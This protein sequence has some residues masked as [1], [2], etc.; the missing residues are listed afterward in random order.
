[1]KAGVNVLDTN[2]LEKDRT[3]LHYAALWNAPKCARVRERERERERE[4]EKESFH[5]CL[6]F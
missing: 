6:F 3:A 5:L 1:M 2:V 4:K